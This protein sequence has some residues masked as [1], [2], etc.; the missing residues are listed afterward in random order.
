MGLPVIRS[1]EIA[2]EKPRYPHFVA[3]LNEMLLHSRHLKKRGDKI[4]DGDIIFA[5]NDPT[6]IE[7]SHLDKSTKRKPDLICLLADKFKSFLDK[8]ITHGFKA[9]M[10]NAKKQDQNSMN[11]KE[12]ATVTWG[13][14]LQSWELEAKG[15]IRSKIR[16]NYEAQ[17]FIYTE[18][19]ESGDELA[20]E[21]T[22]EGKHA[23]VPWIWT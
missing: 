10:I 14:V 15:K 20:D 3:A 5:V 11:A 21:S 23:F 2:N 4:N 7:S 8:R 17:E 9:C 16:T 12:A 13:D 22:S 1:C 6:V 18:E 19:E